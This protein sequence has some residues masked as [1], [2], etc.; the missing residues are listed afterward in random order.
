[1]LQFAVLVVLL[2]VAAA[3]VTVL[4]SV[5]TL[6]SRSP[7]LRIKGTGFEADEHHIFMELSAPGQPPLKQNKDYFITLNKKGLLFKLM[8]KKGWVDLEGRSPPVPLVLNAVRFNDTN[9]ENLLSDNVTLANV[10]LKPTI[11]KNDQ[12]VY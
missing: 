1:M 12:I 10:L 7:K 2:A 3:E 5:Q 4:S 6:Y 9:S 8:A 11:N